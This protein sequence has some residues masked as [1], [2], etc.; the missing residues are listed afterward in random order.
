MLSC[1][2]LLMVPASW[3]TFRYHGCK[4]AWS[5][6][7][8]AFVYLVTPDCVV[9]GL[10]LTGCVQGLLYL[11][12][13]MPACLGWGMFVYRFIL[14]LIRQCSW[15]C[16]SAWALAVQ[17]QRVDTGFKSVLYTQL[18]HSSSI[19][20]HMH[21]TMK[22]VWAVKF[23]TAYF[24]RDISSCLIN[25]QAVIALSAIIRHNKLLIGWL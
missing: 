18:S 5:F 12:Q 17:H 6:Y 15:S 22:H 9:A 1:C 23:S 8:N 11:A 25:A 2:F 21:V 14:L 13:C 4:C 20:N 16:L 7:E 24:Q 3:H 19:C 10:L